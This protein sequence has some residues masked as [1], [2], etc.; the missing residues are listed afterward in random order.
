LLRKSV[1]RIGLGFAHRLDV[2]VHRERERRVPQD[3][4]NGFIFHTQ[5]VKVGSRARGETRAGHA[6]GSPCGE[7]RV[8][9]QEDGSFAITN[10]P[11]PVEWYVYGKM[12]SLT[13]G[14]AT[15]PVRCATTRDKE[16][17]EV[18]DIQ[19]KPGHGLKGQV[20]L[21]DGNPVPNGMRML[22]SSDRAWD[23]QTATLRLDGHFE[24]VGLA[25]GGYSISPAVKGYSLPDGALEVASSIDRDVDSWTNRPH[26]CWPRSNTSV[27][28]N[29]RQKPHVKLA[30]DARLRASG[31]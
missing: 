21:S 9:T 31:R 18:N 7:M 25:V 23:T 28:P 30:C 15:E 1:E 5:R 13:N 12:E 20:I 24:F 3:R 22:I 6:T 17:V 19:V 29:A 26:A 11:S 4:L 8:G 14:G 27:S 2:H 10:V 16:L